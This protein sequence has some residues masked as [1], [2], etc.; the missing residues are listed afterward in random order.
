MDLAV[1]YLAVIGVI[2]HTWLVMQCDAQESLHY[3]IQ[4]E[5]SPGTF[6]GNLPTDSGLSQIYDKSVLSKFS[7]T[8]LQQFKQD[9]QYFQ[10]E[11]HTGVLRTSRRID[12]DM[13]CP[14]VDTCSLSV[15]VAVRHGQHFQVLLITVA[16]QDIN[17]HDPF[18]PESTIHL[19]IPESTPVMTGFGL[20]SAEDPDTGE[21]SVKH[22]ELLASR[23]SDVFGLQLTESLDG[24]DDLQLIVLQPLDREQQSAY[25]I[26]V[27]AVDGGSPLRSGS[28][29]VNISVGDANDHRPE[30]TESTYTVEVP[31]STAVGMTIAAAEARDDDIGP[32]GQITYSFSSKTQAQHGDLFGID[33]QSGY[34]Y[35]LRVLDYEEAQSYHLVVSAKD[36]GPDSRPT[37]AN[38]IINVLDVNDNAPQIIVNTLTSGPV[39]HVAEHSPSRTFVAHVS[40]EDPD[41]GDKGVLECGLLQQEYFELE[42][43]SMGQFKVVTLQELDREQQDTFQVTLVCHDRGQPPLSSR[44]NLTVL[45]TD[46]NDHGPVF[47]QSSY[48]VRQAENNRKG[49]FLLHVSASDEDIGNN[50]LI[51]YELGK[52]APSDL[53][54][55]S[56]EK[57]EITAIGVLDHEKS[58]SYEFTVI[59]K[60]QGNPSNSASAT[61][62]ITILD[63]NDEAPKFRENHYHCAVR[64][65]QKIGRVENTPVAVDMDSYPFNIIEYSLVGDDA[66]VDRSFS[67]NPKSGE[68]DMLREFD[69]EERDRYDMKIIATDID[70][71]WLV[72]TAI[73][74]VTV[75]DINDHEPEVIFP[76]PSNNTVI[77]SNAVPMW[78]VVT[79]V[80]AI[81]KDIGENR[82]LS[83]NLLLGDDDDILELDETG[84]LIVTASLLYIDY[85]MFN[86]TIEVSDHGDPPRSTECQLH[87]VVNSAVPYRGPGTAG[88]DAEEAGLSRSLHSN[89]VIIVGAASAFIIL[90]LIIA[91]LVIHMKDRRAKALHRYNCRLE[92]QRMLHTNSPSEQEK[93]MPSPTFPAQAMRSDYTYQNYLKVNLNASPARTLDDS[94]SGMGPETEGSVDGS[95]NGSEHEDVWQRDESRQPWS[96]TLNHSGAQVI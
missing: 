30:F 11:E 65:H 70:N 92:A 51:H 38:V 87:L 21:N 75:Q 26:T 53:V 63:L 8:I 69:R 67:I 33:P 64:E 50:G 13:L 20:P 16:I 66:E 48:S 58:H 57:G 40:V 45:V 39:A 17:D 72:G 68:I 91:I 84:A 2:L 7:F 14:F 54:S 83:F 74:T 79:R 24:S 86:L 27:I 73:V 61:V 95:R 1:D 10:V 42:E 3:I 49:Q 47:S 90:V 15:D 36:N 60:D 56:A 34:I 52:D 76:S 94:I 55:I 6:I 81:D 78:R 41:S 71:K 25:A 22:Y 23:W 32:N 80:Q 28:V 31:E 77:I 12:R 5:L 62:S 35:T 93:V 82:R 9:T 85:M 59:A 89:I 29:L 18:F 43:M 4:E 37:Y 96:K 88:Q 19:D 46:A 44:H